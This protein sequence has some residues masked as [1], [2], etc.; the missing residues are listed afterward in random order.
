MSLV[1]ANHTDYDALRFDQI[2]PL[3]EPYHV[4][5]VRIGYDLL[6]GMTGQARL[7]E[8][9]EPA[10]LVEE[11]QYLGQINQS[12]VRCESD[13]APYKPR[14]DVILNATAH[15]PGG[16]PVRRFSVGL[17]VRRPD[18][19]VPLPQPP[20]ALNP[21]MPLN[22]EQRAAWQTELA[23]AKQTM[24]P[25]RVL[26]D[27][28][29]VVTGPRQFKK[30]FLLTRLLQGALYY[31][32]LG[33]LR[34]NPWKLSRPG[35][36]T[37]L[38][39]SY[40][41][42]WGGQARINQRDNSHWA[43]NAK[44]AQRWQD[45]PR[46]AERL[47]KATRLTSEQLARHPDTALPSALLPVAHAVCETNPLGRGALPQWYLKASGL[48][49]LPAPQIEYPNAPLSAGGFWQAVH[50]KAS[51]TPAGFGCVGRAW[52]PR[53]RLIGTIEEKDAWAED[54]YPQLPKDFDHRYWNSAPQDQQCPHL[55]GDEIF[56]L[57]NLCPNSPLDSIDNEGNH[58]LRFQLP[59]S[60][61][62]LMFTDADGNQGAKLMDLDTVL[63]EPGNGR[64]ELLW[65]S[66]V[67]ARAELA[68]AQLHIAAHAADRHALK[69]LLPPQQRAE[70]DAEVLHGA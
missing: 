29:L 63:I 45:N 28:M 21:F 65:R 59:G 64:V 37:V 3:G 31:G 17:R 22:L 61:P 38:P 39:L 25:G 13:L 8:A 2:D 16:I 36:I 9:E 48:E 40:E 27:K 23:A 50:G 10:L 67:S 1:F 5:V 51:F 54:E 41:I 15:A 30:K 11:D 32:S 4:F 60:R 56:E 14:C 18:S 62:Y 55:T 49:T 34:T 43:T 44:S 12:S 69:D 6:P 57:T 70:L 24:V 20:Q 53:R 42:A 7:Q 35:K 19:R 66:I 47:P 58:Q 52:Q 46:P 68:E 26:V 33:L